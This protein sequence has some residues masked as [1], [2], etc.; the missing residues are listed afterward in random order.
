M[1][2]HPWTGS[3]PFSVSIA[4]C[5]SVAIGEYMW[6]TCQNRATAWVITS[7]QLFPLNQCLLYVAKNFWY[8]RIMIEREVNRI[9]LFEENEPPHVKT[10]KVAVRPA[11]TQISLGIRPVRSESSLCA[12]WVAKDS[13]FLHADSEDSDQTGRMPRLIWVF[14]GRTVSLLVLSWGGSFYDCI[15]FSFV[16]RL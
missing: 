6:M 10:K 14:T 15:P 8:V 5:V 16:S 7:S 13:S 1:H 2:S 3:S 12:Q 4:T 11:K 9:Y